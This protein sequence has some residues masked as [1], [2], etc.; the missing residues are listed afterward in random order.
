MYFFDFCGT[1][2]EEGDQMA[3][4]LLYGFVANFAKIPVQNKK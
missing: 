1:V 3:F 2:I 4:S